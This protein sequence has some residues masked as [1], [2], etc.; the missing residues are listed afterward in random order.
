MLGIV[1]TNKGDDLFRLNYQPKLSRLKNT[2]RI[3]ASRDLT[4][5]GR[6]IIVKSFGLS[7]LVYLFLVL[8][9]PPSSFIKEVEN[10]IFNFI[11]AGNPDKIK[12]TTIIN[13]ISDGGLKVTHI[14][15]FIDSLKCTWVRRYVDDLNGPWKFFFDSNLSVYGKKYFFNCNC[16]P[17]DVRSIGNNFVRQ[18]MEAWCR[19]SFTT[20]RGDFGIQ[21][22]WNNSN[23]R[24]TGKI[25][26]YSRLFGKQRSVC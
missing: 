4:P 2:L 24:V 14:S 15:T 17:C 9:N 23:I 8:P 25:V 16:S 1:F 26:F 5:I 10:I 7:Q 12:R 21:H 11:W 13:P 3:W 20:P 22:I 18:V 19:A 6:N